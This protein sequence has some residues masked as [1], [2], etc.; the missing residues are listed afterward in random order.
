MLRKNLEGR[1][2]IVTP[3]IRP[4]DNKEIKKGKDDQKR[5]T[6]VE[7]AFKN[8]ADYIVICRPIVKERVP[9]AAAKAIQQQIA[10]LFSSPN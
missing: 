8:G 2:L 10:D 6:G 5:T 4:L 3:D 7:E 1:F 9:L